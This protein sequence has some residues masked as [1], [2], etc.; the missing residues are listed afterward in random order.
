MRNRSR[1]RTRE[2]A[3]LPDAGGQTTA[4]DP[5]AEPADLGLPVIDASA[6]R[7]GLW[8]FSANTIVVLRIHLSEQNAPAHF[9]FLLFF[10]VAPFVVFGVA[11]P[12]GCHSL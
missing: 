11:S 6:C 7:K 1:S 10:L 4:P 2:A 5:G 12:M 9:F 3:R 8:G